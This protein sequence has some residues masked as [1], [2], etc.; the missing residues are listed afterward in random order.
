M[1]LGDERE[2]L[3]LGRTSRTVSTAQRRAVVV[4]DRHCRYPG[5]R[6]PARWCDVHHLVEWERGGPTDLVN[7]ALLCRRHHVAVHEGRRRLVRDSHGTY[8][9]QRRE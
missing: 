7:L 9:V 6:A 1:V 2:V 8:R 5:C 4:R 3:D